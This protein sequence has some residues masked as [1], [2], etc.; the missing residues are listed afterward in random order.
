VLPPQIM[1]LIRQSDSAYLCLD[2]SISLGGNALFRIGLSV[3]LMLATVA[4]PWLCCCQLPS[5]SARLVAL[6]RNE[7]APPAGTQHSCCH[8][9][10]P[11]KDSRPTSPPKAPSCPCQ[12]NPSALVLLESGGARQVQRDSNVQAIDLF[13]Y[14]FLTGIVMPS[15]GMIRTC[16]PQSS[17]VLTGRDILSSL[18][19]LRC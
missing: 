13:D 4:G 15:V 18:H 17:P 10:V 3:Y 16:S 2:V 5:F 11:V 1:R 12:G 19:I 7:A 9:G 14:D 6:L 8:R